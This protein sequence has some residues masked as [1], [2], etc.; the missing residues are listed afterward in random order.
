MVSR[1]TGIES[2]WSMTMRR[3]YVVT[4]YDDAVVKDIYRDSGEVPVRVGA[5]GAAVTLGA[6]G[7]YPPVRGGP[8]W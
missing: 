4:Y 8:C 1:S 7:K 6:Y 3:Y 5:S 2:S